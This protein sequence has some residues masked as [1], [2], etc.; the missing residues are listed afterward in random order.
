MQA[1]SSDTRRWSF[2]AAAAVVLLLVL[3]GCAPTYTDYSAFISEPRPLVSANEYLL[4]PPD[5]I[6]VNSKRVREINEHVEMI[7]PDG[8]ISLPLLG[9]IFVTGKTCEQVAAEIQSLASSYYEDAD[10]SVFIVRYNSKK[11]YIFGE[12]SHPGTYTY[13]GSNNLL[14]MMAM[15]QPTRLADPGKIQV[16]RP[17]ANGQLVKRM[18]VNLNKMIKRGDTSLNALL[19]EGDVVYVPPNPFATV[20]LAFQ[21]LLLPIRPVAETVRGPADIDTAAGAYGPSSSSN[22]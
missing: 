17:N 12:V 22:E 10:A 16:L 19:V 9:P 15:A 6:K 11:L 5:V 2:A 18:T 1:I 4:A 7:R 8:K 21:Q 3:A 13:D 20:G 14:E